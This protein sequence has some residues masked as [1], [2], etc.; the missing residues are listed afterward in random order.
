MTLSLI[1]QHPGKESNIMKRR[2]A[3]WSLDYLLQIL[4]GKGT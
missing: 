2:K 4:T 1:K 3:G